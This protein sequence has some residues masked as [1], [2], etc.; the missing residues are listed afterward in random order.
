MSDLSQRESEALTLAAQGLP[1]KEIAEAM[2]ISPNTV[3]QHMSSAFDK[4]GVS[5]RTEAV[6]KALTSGSIDAPTAQ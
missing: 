6:V 3:K 1:N 2:D 4:M 5:N